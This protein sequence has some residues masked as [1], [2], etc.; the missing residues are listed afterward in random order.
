MP[1]RH[2]LCVRLQV[3]PRAEVVVVELKLEMIALVS[4]L[5]TSLSSV[6]TTEGLGGMLIF[7]ERLQIPDDPL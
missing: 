5:S 6:S 4:M 3:R 1:A 2:V 7:H